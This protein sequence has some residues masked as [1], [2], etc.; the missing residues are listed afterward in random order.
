M[1][2]NP[3]LRKRMDIGNWYDWTLDKFRVE[4]EEKLRFVDWKI[5]NDEF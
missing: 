4:D 5:H 1:I 3:I 2:N